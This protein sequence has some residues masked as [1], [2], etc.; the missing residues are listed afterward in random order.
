MPATPPSSL[1]NYKESSLSEGEDNVLR[2]ALNTAVPLKSNCPVEQH[3]TLLATLTHGKNERVTGS[4]FSL[5]HV[6]SQPF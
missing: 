2:R 6:S 1:V 3:P 4:G 5:V